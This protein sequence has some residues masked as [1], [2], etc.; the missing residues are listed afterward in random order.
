MNIYALFLRLGFNTHEN[1]T[2]K[3][4]I[5]LEKIESYLDLKVRWLKIEYDTDNFF[6]DFC[7]TE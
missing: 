4:Q 5:T 2:P 3:D 6:A 7:A 1:L